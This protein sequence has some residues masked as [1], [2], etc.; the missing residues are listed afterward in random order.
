MKVSPLSPAIGAELSGISLD[1]AMS[2]TAVDDI[3]AALLSHKVVFFRDQSLTAQALVDVAR[4]FGELSIYPFVAGMDGHPEVVEVAKRAEETHNF[5]GLWHSDTT[6]LETPPLGSMLYAR[7]LPPIGGDTLFANMALAFES[8]SSGL[9]ETLVKLRA[10]NSAE[11]PDAAAGR[12]D[13]MAERGLN[14]N[15]LTTST[16]PVVRTHPETGQKALYVNG[17]HTVAFEGM[18]AEESQPL[19]KYLYQ[20]QQR[21]EFS[22]RFTWTPGAVAF[23]DN[24]AAQHNALNDY[25]GHDRVMWRVTLAG[26]RPA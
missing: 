21:P 23:W 22:C 3:R 19:L 14:A 10:I 24:R 18:S 16:H 17:G 7:T 8:L 9:R 2:Q 26:D 6:Y 20:V 12:K 4:R 11:K 15:L 1:P 5:G 13:R 25:H